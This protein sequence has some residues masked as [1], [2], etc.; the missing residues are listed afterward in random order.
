MPEA[1]GARFFQNLRPF[2]ACTNY[3]IAQ[4]KMEVVKGYRVISIPLGQSAGIHSFYIKEHT[5]NRVD[6]NGC[7]LFVGNIDY[8]GERSH[9]DIDSYTRMLL[10]SFGEIESISVSQFANDKIENRTNARFAHV[11]FANKKSIKLAMSAKETLFS[12]I[13]ESIAQEWGVQHGLK[14]RTRA[15]LNSQFQYR[16]EL[17]DIS[18]L[19]SEVNEYLKD[20]EESEASG[21]LDRLRASNAVDDDGFM[22]VHHRLVFCDLFFVLCV[23][24]FQWNTFQEEKEE[25]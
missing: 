23:K 18:S 14:K 3:C 8:C 4:R 10:N 13:G 21:R 6:K 24:T 16:H 20:F 15:E 25:I 12:E 19:K 1:A 7:T 17:E 9:Q 5:E 11:V 22:P 2:F